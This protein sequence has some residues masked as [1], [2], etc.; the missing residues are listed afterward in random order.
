MKIRNVVNYDGIYAVSDSGR[1]FSLQRGIEM[2]QQELQGYMTVK[3]H[4]KGK[5][6]NARVHRLVYE[7]FKGRIIPNLVIDHID[8]NRTNNNLSN[9]RQITTRENTSRGCRNHKTSD[10]PV[11]VRKFK[12]CGSFGAEINIE[13]ERFYLGSFHTIEEASLVYQQALVNWKEKGIKPIKKDKSVKFCATCGHR[14]PISEFYYIR[15]H[16]LSWKC[17]DCS[18]AYAQRMRDERKLSRHVASGDVTIIKL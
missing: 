4:C 7:A 16:G 5:L 17:K 8:G 3:L 13:G 11:G 10:L 18:R 6:V 9:L 2:K 14:K 12:H 1:V 15:N